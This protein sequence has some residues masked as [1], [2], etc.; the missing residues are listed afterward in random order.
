MFRSRDIEIIVRQDTRIKDLKDATTPTPPIESDDN[1]PAD[2]NLDTEKEPR[3]SGVRQRSREDRNNIL[4]P[5]RINKTPGKI[6]F[7]R[8]SKVADRN[9]KTNNDNNNSENEISE[10]DVDDFKVQ[11]KD[12]GLRKDVRF[13]NFG[14]GITGRNLLGCQ[15]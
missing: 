4:F 8:R 11:G 13:P 10:E 5:P 15:F 1:P 2:H 9:V 12:S 14:T 7:P 6:T 3:F